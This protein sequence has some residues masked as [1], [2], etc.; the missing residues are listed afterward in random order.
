MS[1]IGTLVHIAH[2]KTKIELWVFGISQLS[3][4]IAI[5]IEAGDDK[6]YEYRTRILIVFRLI[7]VFMTIASVIVG[8]LTTLP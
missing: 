2:H 3:C 8:I 7:A 6:D 1:V 4:L 5:L